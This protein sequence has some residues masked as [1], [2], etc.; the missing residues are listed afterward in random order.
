[1][2]TS[3]RISAVIPVSNAPAD[4]ED[5]FRAVV[6]GTENE[7]WLRIMSLSDGFDARPVGSYGRPLP[8][9]CQGGGDGTGRRDSARLPPP[10]ATAGGEG[11]RVAPLDLRIIALKTRFTS[12]LRPMILRLLG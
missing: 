8:D 5:T 3:P 10:G 7:Y 12:L 4:G 9:P 6:T 11:E 1:M 2:T